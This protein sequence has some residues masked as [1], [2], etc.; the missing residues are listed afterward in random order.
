MSNKHTTNLVNLAAP[1]VYRNIDMVIEMIRFFVLIIFI[2]TTIIKI[3]QLKLKRNRKRMMI[4]RQLQTI[5][6]SP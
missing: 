4:E 5:K 1:L 2:E 3:F 6:V